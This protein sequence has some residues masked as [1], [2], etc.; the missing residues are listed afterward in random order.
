MPWKCQVASVLPATRRRRAM[1]Y[2]QCVWL[3]YLLLFLWWRYQCSVNEGN[4]QFHH[5][6]RLMVYRKSRR[7]ENNQTFSSSFMSFCLYYSLLL[8]ITIVA[9]RCYYYCCWCFLF[10]FCCFFCLCFSWRL[11]TGALLHP[12]IGRVN[13]SYPSVV[14][15][16]ELI[17]FSLKTNSSRLEWNRAE[18]TSSRQSCLTC[19]YSTSLLNCCVP[20]QISLWGKCSL[21]RN[22]ETHLKTPQVY[23]GITRGF[24]DIIDPFGD[25][26]FFLSSMI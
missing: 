19:F 9:L 4:T 25:I 7:M 24:H 5:K 3:L 6:S 21:F 15:V 8:L 17:M 16:T 2:H 23:H 14:S 20:K 10:F 22:N 18:A 12:F 26:T 1:E 11:A 13:R